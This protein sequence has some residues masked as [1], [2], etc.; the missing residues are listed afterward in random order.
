VGGFPLGTQGEGRQ[1]QS[2]ANNIV[3]KSPSRA[4]NP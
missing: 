4:L 2:K 1:Q 3:I